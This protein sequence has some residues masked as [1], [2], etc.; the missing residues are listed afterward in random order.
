MKLYDIYIKNSLNRENKRLKTLQITIFLAVIAFSLFILLFGTIVR[1]DQ[2]MAEKIT[3]DFHTRIPVS[4]DSEKVNILESNVNIKKLGYLGKKGIEKGSDNNFSFHI[5]LGDKNYF[6]TM[7]V[8]LSEGELPRKENEVLI[9]KLTAKDLNLQV[10]E[11]LNTIDKDNVKH[12]YKITG[13]MNYYT[14]SWEEEIPIYSYMDSDALKTNAYRVV[15]WYKNIK[16]TYKL[17]PKLYDILGIDYEKAI[18]EGDFGYNFLYLSSHFVNPDDM[19]IYTSSER[20]PKIFVM[21]LILIGGFFIIIIK[22]IFLVWEKSHIREYG[23]LLSVGARK[24]D[25]VKMIIKRLIKIAIKPILLG[26]IAGTMLDF[27]IIRILNKYYL[28]SQMNMSSENIKNLRVIISPLSILIIL[29]VSTLILLVASLSPVFKLSKLNP[30]DS[31]KLYRS[32]DKHSRKSYKLRRSNFIGDLSKINAKKD[33]KKTLITTLSVSIS[34]LLLSVLLALSSALD[35]ELKHNRPNELSYYNHKINYFSPQAIPKDLISEL[36]NNFEEEYISYRKYGFYIELSN[37]YEKILD[38][39]Y[40]RELYPKY[41]EDNKYEEIGINLIGIEGNK[42]GEIVENFN[43]K[44]EDFSNGNKCIIVNTIPIDFTKPYSRLE[45]T[46]AIDENVE[47]IRVN[48]NPSSFKEKLEGFDLEVLD[49]TM[50]PNILKIPQSRTSLIAIMPMDNFISILNNLDMAADVF[51]LESLYLKTS[52]Y[53]SL[54][55]IKNKTKEYLNIRDL[56]F[57]NRENLYAFESNSNKMLYSLILIVTIF[58]AIVGISSSYGATNSMRESRKQ[59]FVL[60]QMVGMDK[61][62]LK[63]LII[64]EVNYNMLFIV[65]ISIFFLLISA[66]IG[67]TAYDFFKTFEVLLNMKIYLWL[68][69]LLLIYIILRKN[70][71]KNLKDVELTMNS[72]IM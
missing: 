58:I 2:E 56:E 24:I 38:Q 31:M 5:F 60:L 69:Y 9:P 11:Y 14:R 4:L 61:S 37:D 49:Y 62:I 72:R 40:L 15:I 45:Y 20:Y 13:L 42:F 52:E 50:D 63:K 12:D 29:V 64:R 44:L 23:L 71:L 25:I 67:T 16:D 57:F 34:L 46:D 33:R 21:G 41:V 53:A 18:N 30:I 1:N 43:L 68:L 3:G 48:A 19:R 17:T 36:T 10:G 54:E 8:V 51:N 55:E 70:Y 22:N 65:I 47:T 7:K 59:E 66:Y 35:L 39:E 28:L 32:D 27:F 26:V 6:D